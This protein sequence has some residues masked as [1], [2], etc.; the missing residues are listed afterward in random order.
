MIGRRS[1]QNCFELS[2]QNP[3]TR[4]FRDSPKQAHDEFSIM[5]TKNSLSVSIFM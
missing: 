1:E 2:G 5:D 4:K 3:Y